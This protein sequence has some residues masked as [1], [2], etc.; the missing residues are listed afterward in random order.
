MCKELHEEMKVEE[1]IL[2]GQS[3]GG[4]SILETKA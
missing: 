4:G 2:A 1:I 3:Y